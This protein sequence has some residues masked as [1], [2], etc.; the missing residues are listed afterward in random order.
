MTYLALALLPFRRLT[1]E[2]ECDDSNRQ[3]LRLENNQREKTSN[4]HHL[5]FPS[6]SKMRSKNAGSE[7]DRKEGAG[8]E[9]ARRKEW[10]KEGG[11]DG[12]IKEEGRE[13]ER[14]WEEE[15][16]RWRNEGRTGVTTEVSGKGEQGRG[17][18]SHHCPPTSNHFFLSFYLSK[19]TMYISPEKT[20]GILHILHFSLFSCRFSWMWNRTWGRKRDSFFWQKVLGESSWHTRYSLST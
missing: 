5:L 4:T 11:R 7:V 16:K 13:K 8:R 6:R 18:G 14:R 15:T 3:N 2:L 17:E 9:K 19:M 12:G 10:W 20:T 1:R